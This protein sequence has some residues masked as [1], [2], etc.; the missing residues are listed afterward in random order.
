MLQ[1]LQKLH[2][3]DAELVAGLVAIFGLEEVEFACGR[4]YHLYDLAEGIALLG[5]S[6]QTDGNLIGQD[7]VL[8]V[9]VDVSKALLGVALPDELLACK[10][11]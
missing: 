7:G 3:Y 9:Q 8:D 1:R 6:L 4:L 5:G 11:L 10:D 2:L